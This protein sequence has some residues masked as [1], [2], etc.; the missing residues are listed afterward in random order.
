MNKYTFKNVSDVPLYGGC[1]H[2]ITSWEEWRRAHRAL[3]IDTSQERPE[4]RASQLLDDKTGRTHYLIGVFSK[5]GA[6]YETLVHEC[7]HA[8]FFILN[9]AGI[10]P[11][12]SQGEAYCYVLDW[13][14]KQGTRYIKP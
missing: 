2:Y 13:L 4:G 11:R 14:F 10:D 7:G 1:V 5:S 9:R 12:D 3:G 6:R 8:A